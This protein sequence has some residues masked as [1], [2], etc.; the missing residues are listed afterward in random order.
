[1]FLTGCYTIGEKK[2]PRSDVD[3]TTAQHYV[4]TN[5]TFYKQNEYLTSAD[6]PIEDSGLIQSLII[7]NDSIQEHQDTTNKLL[8]ANNFLQENGNSTIKGS[9]FNLG[10][11]LSGTTLIIIGIL[12]FTTPLGSWLFFAYRRVRKNLKL[13]VH[14]IKEDETKNKPLLNKLSPKMDSSDKLLISKIKQEK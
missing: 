1:M 11:P 4:E 13:I 12:C 9:G 3:S 2:I 7:S 14:T 5:N 6:V 8:Q 10:I